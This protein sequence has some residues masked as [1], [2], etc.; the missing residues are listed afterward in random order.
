MR[1]EDYAHLYHNRL[2]DDPLPLTNVYEKDYH[3]HHNSLF[4]DPLPFI[5]ILSGANNILY[6]I[7]IF[8][9]D[10]YIIIFMVKC[11]H[12]CGK[13]RWTLKKNTF[14]FL[15]ISEEYTST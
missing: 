6:I 5:P 12:T 14:S 9:N 3:P 11:H 2:F 7:L 15:Y 8:F 4:D 10:L 1:K 13:Y